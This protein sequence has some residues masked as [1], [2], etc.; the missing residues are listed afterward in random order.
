MVTVPATIIMG[1]IQGWTT[2]K[3]TVVVVVVV[4]PNQ[5]IIPAAGTVT[6]VVAIAA[7][8]AAAVVPATE[9]KKGMCMMDKACKVH[10]FPVLH[11]TA[12]HP[13]L[14]MT[15]LYFGKILDESF[16]KLARCNTMGVGSVV[17]G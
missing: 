6:C 12:T 10:H 14:A 2:I 8:V 1:R 15:T 9:P 16:K 13:Q 4:A 11:Q 17:N 5:P 7:P 3:G